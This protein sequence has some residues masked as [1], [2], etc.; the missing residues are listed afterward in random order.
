MARKKKSEKSSGNTFA[1]ALRQCVDA[2]KVEFGANTGIKRALMG[3]AKL[4]VLAANCPKEVSEDVLRFCKLSGVQTAVFEGTSIELG[5]A[6][7]RPHPV[8]VLT[9]Y[10]VGNSSIMD[11]AK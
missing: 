10:D 4:V 9:V 8:S 2:G 3:K 1:H 5:T 6:T 11:Y 7:G